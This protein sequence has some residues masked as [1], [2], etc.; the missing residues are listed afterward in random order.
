RCG[1]Q[2]AVGRHDEEQSEWPVG[3]DQRRA[4]EPAPVVAEEERG[5]AERTGYV[6]EARLHDE[7]A[8]VARLP[9]REHGAV[10]ELE[11]G[12]LF[13]EVDVD[14]GAGEERRRYQG[15]FTAPL[16]PTHLIPLS[17]PAPRRSCAAEFLR[18]RR[19]DTG[20]REPLH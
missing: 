10:V 20:I 2:E 6:R 9:L 14:G 5:D 16:G 12:V 3:E 19:P 17:L 18:L 4:D 1:A 13:G 11:P 8:L 7:A 15:Q